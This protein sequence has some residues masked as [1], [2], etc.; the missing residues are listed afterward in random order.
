MLQAIGNFI[1][2]NFSPYLING[3]RN[4]NFSN[5]HAFITFVL[6]AAPMITIYF[7]LRGKVKRFTMMLFVFTKNTYSKGKAMWMNKREEKDTFLAVEEGNELFCG[8][9]ISQMISVRLFGREIKRMNH[10]SSSTELFEKQIEQYIHQNDLSYSIEE[11]D[12]YIKL[13]VLTKKIRFWVLEM[14]K[15][16]PFISFVNL[17]YILPD[18]IHLLVLGTTRA[19]KTVTYNIPQLHYFSK[20]KKYEEK[21]SLIITDPKGELYRETSGFMEEGGYEVHKIDLVQVNKSD[22]YNQFDII[23]QL[24]LKEYN[25]LDIDLEGISRKEF[26]EISS[27]LDTT[28]VE[29]EILKIANNLYPLDTEGQNA[30]FTQLA[31]SIFRTITMLYLDKCVFEQDYQNFNVFGMILYSKSILKMKM[32]GRDKVP[33]IK[34]IVDTLP[35]KH[36]AYRTYSSSLSDRTFSSTVTTFENILSVYSTKT[37]ENVTSSS[38]V[39]V[40]DFATGEKPIAYYVITPDYDTKYN[41]IVTT[42]INQVYTE[43]VIYAD[44]HCNGKLPRRLLFLLEEFANIPKIENFS[45]KTTVSLGRGIQF[46]MTIQNIAQL[47]SVYGEDVAE[48]ILD[49]AHAKLYLLAG[50]SDTREWFSKEIGATTQLSTS[51]MG[52]NYKELSKTVAEEEVRLVTPEILSKNPFGIGYLSLLK[53]NPTQVYL[54][55]SFT[56]IKSSNKIGD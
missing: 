47:K 46:L 38:S 50:S 49:N 4:A 44:T 13:A 21:P 8:I 48:T 15:K 27:N 16:I 26:Y 51:Y 3:T 32:I 56:Y 43:C 28:Y 40:S 12:R 10:F 35:P 30:I 14:V 19:G 23:L 33:I 20:I 24:Y 31:N 55:P 34:N 36:G 5:E 41:S 6:V 1:V 22:K 29:D 17:S 39:N 54:R 7:L 18:A 45:N 42:L 37:M 53:N 52:K 11:T 2:N 25:K 9:L